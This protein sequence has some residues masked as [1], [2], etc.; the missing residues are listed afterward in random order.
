[1]TCSMTSFNFINNL[2]T[3]ISLLFIVNIWQCFFITEVKYN[4]LFCA[5]NLTFR[6][7]L[8]VQLHVLKGMKTVV[9]DNMVLN[10]N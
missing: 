7:G 9:G 2:K 1:M 8:C 10:R 3:N 5:G 4:L 6:I